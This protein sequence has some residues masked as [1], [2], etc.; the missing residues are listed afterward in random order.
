M[1]QLYIVVDAA[2]SGSSFTNGDILVKSDM[3]DYIH[4]F[5]LEGEIAWF[6]AKPAIGNSG[7]QLMWQKDF[8]HVHTDGRIE[9]ITKNVIPYNP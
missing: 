9:S 5:P 7:A 8:D 1:E 2:G 4:T 3:D 6:K